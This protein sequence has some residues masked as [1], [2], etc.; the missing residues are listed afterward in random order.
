MI[1]QAEIRRIAGALGVAPN[2]ID[3]DYALGC[4]LHFLSAQK[5]VQRSWVFKGG[6]ALSKCHFPSYRFSEDLDF[7]L[8]ESLSPDG[9]MAVIHDA[10]VE[11]EAEIGIRSSFRPLRLDVIND[12]YGRE[13]FEVKLYYE[14]PWAY[15]GS[16]RSLQ[17]HA[18]RDED[19]AFP[20]V[21][22]AIAHGFSDRPLLPDATI[23]VYALEEVLVE[24]LRA[25]SGQRRFA[26]ARDLFDIWFLS[27][28]ALNLGGVAQA[29]RTKCERKGLDTRIVDVSAIS[30]RKAEYEANWINNLA[31]LLPSPLQASFEDA[32]DRSIKLL[33]DFV[34]YSR[35]GTGA[36]LPR[37]TDLP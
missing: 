5:D 19:L 22:L 18:S 32:W 16:Q 27:G 7:T 35:G 20:P 24:K 17:V 9:I 37:E 26:I 8:Q 21:S 11:M 2:I 12:E 15:G 14:G 23:R 31:S 6:T 13:S 36:T 33:H 34:E 30:L 10:Q 4:F 3:H 1:D 28:K 29:Y 25:I